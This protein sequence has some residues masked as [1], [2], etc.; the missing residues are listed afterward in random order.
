[1]MQDW[2]AALFAR[3]TLGVR[4]GTTS[5]STVLDVLAPDLRQRPP[6]SV[7]Q[8]VGTN[9]KGSTAA[10]LEHGL[11][12]R[13]LGPVGLYTSPHLLRV[14]E[15]VRIDGVAVDDE[16]IR[17][18]VEAIAAAE[19]QVGVSLSFFEVLTAIALERFVAAGC[20]HVVLEAGLGGRL[21]AT[22]A[23]AREQVLI[24]R[25][26][27]DH[28]RF[29]GDTIT[30][31]AGEKAAVIRPGVPVAS[32][33]QLDEARVV[34]EQ[35]ARE[36]GAPLQ[37]VEPLDRP[38]IGLLGEHQRHNAALAL[39][40]LRRVVANASIELLDGV[41]WPGRLERRSVGRGELWLDVAHN[42]DGIEAL[43]AAIEHLAIRPAVIVFGTMA[44]KPAPAMARSLRSLAPLWLVPPAAEGAFELDALAEPGDLRFPA[45][46][47]PSLLQQFHARLDAGECVLVC[48]SH[49]LVGALGSSGQSPEPG[50]PRR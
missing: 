23:V 22:S 8:I 48:G 18:G 27:F 17:A 41:R 29:L 24:G 33:A 30:A 19:A 50:D 16:A 36:R 49:H 35:V 15:R 34:I 46:G 4:L 31:I 28:E 6:F 38:P 26:G 12:Q 2:R 5:L 47:D 44:D 3:R 25:I 43:C 9:G 1:M 11:R 20:R 21:D 45:A 39:A 32:V 14:G 42:L 40:G 7:T 10:M 13:G 37:F